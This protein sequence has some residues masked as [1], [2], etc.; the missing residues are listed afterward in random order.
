MYEIKDTLYRFF[1]Y[2]LF[3]TK[4]NI[5][6]VKCRTQFNVLFSAGRQVEH[7][8]KYSLVHTT[9]RQNSGGER[10]KTDETFIEIFLCVCERCVQMK[11]VNFRMVLSLYTTKQCVVY[12]PTYAKR[13]NIIGSKM[14][15]IKTFPI[16][17]LMF[18]IYSICYIWKKFNGFFK[19]RN[20]KNQY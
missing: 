15:Q 6:T 16:F 14:W 17:K 7:I 1:L 13:L 18:E 19:P 10:T 12:M 20:E 3:V 8:C 4:R 5:Y 2:F 11:F 9:M